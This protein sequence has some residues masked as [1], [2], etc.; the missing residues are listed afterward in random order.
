M[1]ILALAGILIGTLFLI[2]P[3]RLFLDRL[4]LP[5]VSFLA[6]HL[7]PQSPVGSRVAESNL[8]ELVA[9]LIRENAELT[10]RLQG[11]AHLQASLALARRQRLA[12]FSAA[13]LG[14]EGGGNNP[15]K[16]FLVVPLNDKLKIEAGLP[17]LAGSSLVGLT[18][19]PREGIIPIMPLTHPDFR[20]LVTLN[21][22][23]GS[24]QGIIETTPHGVP[25]VR[26]LPAD[27][28]IKIGTP[29]TTASRVKN[30]PPYL[31]VGVVEE[32]IRE[33]D[34]LTQSV[35]LTP[36]TSLD[37]ETFVLIISPS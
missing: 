9:Q 12:S 22:E 36:L 1:K 11:Q 13:P 20:L 21:S 18:M 26:F 30:I 19:S 4:F 2:P 23:N 34:G 29:L 14:F 25:I 24:A 31:P 16:L 33:P 6:R 17:V 8:S 37:E 32:V 7:A 5:P 27:Q 10:S 15:R 28:E 3:T 35:I